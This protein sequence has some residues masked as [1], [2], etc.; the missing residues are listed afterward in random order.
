MSQ[1][2][3]TGTGSGMETAASITNIMSRLGRLEEM[4]CAL[5][6]KVGDV[7][8]QQQVCGI[9]LVLLEQGQVNPDANNQTPLAWD[10]ANSGAV[11]ERAS[12][13]HSVAPPPHAKPRGPLPP[14]YHHYAQED[15]QDDDNFLPTYHKLDFPKFD[16]SYNLLTWLNRCE[17]YFL[18]RRMPDHKRVSYA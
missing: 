8:Q 4:M 18:V 6:A 9:A 7:D 13:D 11:G 12:D 1:P 2:P 15:D 14:H 10:G 5:T 16:G 17:H 3:A